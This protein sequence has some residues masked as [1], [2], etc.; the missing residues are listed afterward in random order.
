MQ[1]MVAIAKDLGSGR[2]S[3]YLPMRGQKR[4]ATKAHM[5]VITIKTTAA[6]GP[7]MSSIG[8]RSHVFVSLGMRTLIEYRRD[9]ERNSNVSQ[10]MKNPVSCYRKASRSPGPSQR[11]SA[12][13]GQARQTG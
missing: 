12:P 8:R 1:S 6:S 4:Q 2:A 3:V 10:I 9:R 11:Q 7:V 13:K 5:V